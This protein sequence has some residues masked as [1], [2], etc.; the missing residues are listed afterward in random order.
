ME[1][2]MENEIQSKD[3]KTLSLDDLVNTL[4]TL[5]EEKQI[6]D[7]KED[8]NAIRAAFYLQYNEEVA[9]AKEDFIAAGGKEEEFQYPN[10]IQV[11]FKE[12]W[13]TFLNKKK[14]HQAQL[15]KELENN[16]SKR[17]QI[18]AAIKALVEQGDVS[19]SYK[20]FQQ[21]M[22][23]W[24]EI[25]NI[26][27]DK[28][29]ETW[30]NYHLYV[31]QFYDLLHLNKDLREIDF[32]RNLEAKQQ[33]IE[34]AKELATHTDI[35]FAFNELQILHRLWK[36]E[37]GPVS[38]EF[39]E[40]VWQEF[41]EITN[42]IHQKR[43]AF[44]N[45][46]KKVEEENLQSKLEKIEEIRN[47][48]FSKNRSFNDWRKSIDAFEVLKEQ[49]LAIG[50]IPKNKT[51]EVWNS[52]KEATKVFNHAKNDFF[53]EQKKAQA[54]AIAK[55][56]ELIAEA[57]NW[58]DSEDFQSATETFKRIQAEWKKLGFVPRKQADAL[59]NEFKNNC[60]AYFDRLNNVKKEGTPEEQKNYESKLA[61]FETLTEKEIN[62]DTY[63]D[64]VKE[65]LE[66]GLVPSQKNKID[67]DIYQTIEKS[68]ELPKEKADFVVYQLKL[69]Y[70]K[71]I[72]SKKLYDEYD[73]LRKEVDA[74]TKDLKQLENNLGFFANSKK[75]NPL[76]DTVKQ[77]IENEKNKLKLAKQKVKY[78]RSIQ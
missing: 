74:V 51:A 37:T 48:D 69:A 47:F 24:K 66:I 49:F 43:V 59:W 1:P 71:A 55:R 63:K 70:W 73:L 8:A 50:N 72:D 32:K 16:L 22:T 10:P 67:Q 11:T 41:S 40:P 56:K 12:L 64:V 75:A 6:T 42:Q 18:I 57:K 9:Q 23:D 5:I 35:Q 19:N 44:V 60:D 58:K 61:F 78:F 7:I 65:W 25:G 29:Q 38:K 28:Y 34:K 39:R 77:S 68:L 76:L 4:R 45:E 13:K 17:L 46:L 62:I 14:A 33:I 20:D 26:P 31:E 52:F 53:R 2:I 30:G 21:L 3:Y 15:N 54:D 36:E 27:S